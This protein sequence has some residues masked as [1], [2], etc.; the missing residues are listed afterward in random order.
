M[1]SKHIFFVLG[2]IE[3]P[4]LDLLNLT[5]FVLATL[6]I[7]LILDQITSHLLICILLLVKLE[8]F[9]PLAEF[10]LL[11]LEFSSHR[12]LPL[13]GCLAFGLSLLIGAQN[14]VLVEGSPFIDFVLEATD[15][16]SV[17]VSSCIT[18]DTKVLSKSL[19]KQGRRSHEALSS[20]TSSHLAGGFRDLGAS[21]S[22]IFSHLITHV[23]V[24]L[25][26]LLQARF[27]VFVLISVCIHYLWAFGC[28]R[29]R[30]ENTSTFPV[31]Q[32]SF[33]LLSQIALHLYLLI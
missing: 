13:T 10:M 4:L 31:L 33:S 32:N 14:I 23:L 25:L 30:R 26:N 11:L 27:R 19:P 12:K 20:A 8:K 7:D 9:L 28:H 18:T 5:H 29:F 3:A 2:V 17:I 22:S 21:R 15:V 6:L 1:T 16:T 24:A